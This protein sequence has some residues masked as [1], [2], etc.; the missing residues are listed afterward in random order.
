M[1][2][3]NIFTGHPKCLYE[4]KH[5]RY[6]INEDIDIAFD[7]YNPSGYI[8]LK[9]LDNIDNTFNNCSMYNLLVTDKNFSIQSCNRSFTVAGYAISMTVNAKDFQNSTVFFINL[10]KQYGN[11]NCTFTFQINGI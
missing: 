5:N 1:L 11:E 7:V 10:G 2:N 6:S 8:D 4:D 9:C 3:F